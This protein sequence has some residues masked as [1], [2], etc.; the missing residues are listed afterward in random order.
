MGNEER[1]GSMNDSK[2][3]KGGKVDTERRK[4]RKI[5]KERKGGTE[6]MVEV[7]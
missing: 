7:I 3:A 6:G 2:R 4:E 5:G 1:R